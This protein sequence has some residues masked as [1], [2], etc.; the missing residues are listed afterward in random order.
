MI[1]YFDGQV[2]LAYEFNPPAM[3]RHATP[4]DART[5]RIASEENVPWG[6]VCHYL[7]RRFGSIEEAL[8]GD[9][10]VKIWIRTYSVRGGG[11]FSTPSDAYVFLES[12]AVI[13]TSREIAEY[14]AKGEPT[15]VCLCRDSWTGAGWYADEYAA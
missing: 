2:M 1:V 8:G 9:G 3:H 11:G 7:P 5:K 6:V 14:L 4:E 10:I 13:T 12:G 15:E